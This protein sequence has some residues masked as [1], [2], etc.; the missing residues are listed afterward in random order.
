MAPVAQAIVTLEILQHNLQMARLIY[1]SAQ[2]RKQFLLIESENE[3][4]AWIQQRI[5]ELE[6]QVNQTR[7]TN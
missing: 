2:R 7:E 5:D 4:I 6:R 3:R 1:E